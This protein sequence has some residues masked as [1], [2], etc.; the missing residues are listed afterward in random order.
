MSDPVTTD[1]NQCRSA[2]P[3]CWTRPAG[4]QPD[5][6]TNQCQ[7]SSSSPATMARTEARW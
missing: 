3:R 4:V 6:T 5:G 7:A 2:S 1:W